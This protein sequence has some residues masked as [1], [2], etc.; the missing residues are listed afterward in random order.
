MPYGPLADLWNVRTLNRLLWS[1]CNCEPNNVRPMATLAAQLV[2]QGFEPYALLGWAQACNGRTYPPGDPVEWKCIGCQER[3]KTILSKI[4]IPY[5]ELP[6]PTRLPQVELDWDPPY[7]PGQGPA[8]SFRDYD[9]GDIAKASIFRMVQRTELVPSDRDVVVWFY[10]HALAA[11]EESERLLGSGCFGSVVVFQGMPVFDRVLVEVSR[12]LG[13]P[14]FA[15]ENTS[16]RNRKFFV[17]GGFV[18]NRHPL[19]RE[20]YWKPLCGRA[21]TARQESDLDSILRDTFAGSSQIWQPAVNASGARQ[22]SDLPLDRP[23]VLVLGQ[24]PCDSVISHDSPIYPTTVDFFLE[25]I[26]RFRNQLSEYNLVIR[27]HPLEARIFGSSSFCELSQLDLPDNVWLIDGSSVNTYVL[28]DHCLTGV[29]INSQTGLELVAKGKRPLICGTAFYAGKGF[30]RDLRSRGDLSTALQ[31]ICA[32]P[33]LNEDEKVAARRFLYHLLFE[34][35]LVWDQEAN[36][37]TEASIERARSLLPVSITCAGKPPAPLPNLAGQTTELYRLRQ[38]M[39]EPAGDTTLEFLGSFGKAAESR[40][41]CLARIDLL[42]ALGRD[43]EAC[44]RVNKLALERPGDLDVLRRLLDCVYLGCQERTSILTPAYF[45]PAHILSRPEARLVLGMAAGCRGDLVKAKTCLLDVLNSLPQE[46]LAQL[47]LFRLALRF[48]DASQHLDARICLE[49]IAD[50]P[51][52]H[53]PDLVRPQ[54]LAL[55]RESFRRKIP[56]E[57]IGFLDFAQR[58]F[59]R[60]R[61][62]KR[63]L[64]AF[65]VRTGQL[66]RALYDAVELI[67]SYTLAF[68][69]RRKEHRRRETP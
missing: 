32:R 29:V 27:F 13:V 15:Y 42:Q 61:R 30:T 12:H 31:D 57:I 8:C 35:V 43:A 26:D 33:R 36:A 58:S 41:R 28:M 44:S 1:F 11:I 56:L 14:A 53:I 63:Y 21:L 52:P 34:Y 24:V 64:L 59:P 22:M 38:A 17:P 4:G 39:G 40:E 5:G 60:S 47:E 18:V 55:F 20:E 7:L 62:L 67:H 2:D 10:R 49:T 23:F 6:Y 46:P 45:L 3:M 19:A 69:G 16:F 9:L 65:H 51:T 66:Q 54:Y 25:L 50:M 68:G 37:F 48:W